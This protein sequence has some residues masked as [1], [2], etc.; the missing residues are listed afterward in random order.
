[1]TA[2]K[3]DFGGKP[4]MAELPVDRLHVDGVYQRDTKS[5]RSRTMIK[6]IV[7]N[8]SWLKFGAVTA[9][10]WDEKDSWAIL[11]GQH[12]VEAARDL[13]IKT[14]PCLIHQELSPAEAAGIFVGV[15]CNR[16]TVHSMALHYARLAAQDPE[17][18]EIDEIC[19]R[20]D[21]VICRYPVM[22]DRIKPGET[23]AIG[24]IR[25]SLKNVGREPLQAALSAIARVFRDAPGAVRSD[26]IKGAAA[27][28]SDSS[29]SQREAVEVFLMQRPFDD[30]DSLIDSRR[31]EGPKWAA[32]K[33]AFEIVMQGDKPAA[34]RTAPMHE[35]A[36]FGEPKHRRCE[37]C[38]AVFT[39]RYVD[40]MTCGKHGGMRGAAA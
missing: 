31:G 25:A 24:S 1:M 16:V 6:R 35:R 30:L 14:V 29:A 34:L 5:R 37:I 20:A 39:T 19:T 4:T 36:T 23:M 8:F 22:V 11:D 33:D 13:G 15:N 9:M 7:E 10:Q 40:E 28:F 3:K 26:I 32:Y 21:V 18:M 17:A 12:R 38:G 27:A 2:P